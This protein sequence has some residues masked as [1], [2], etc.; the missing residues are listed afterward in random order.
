MTADAADSRSLPRETQEFGWGSGPAARLL[1]FV[2]V[3][4]SAFQ[5]W[6]A[7]Y[8]PLPS[9]V[10]RAVHVG[11]L[12]LLLFGLVANRAPE[13]RV[14]AGILWALGVMGFAVG[15]Y[16]WFFYA[17]IL[18]RAGDPNGW[19]I[20]VGTLAVVLVFIAG[21]L[22][23]GWALPIICA[24]FLAYGM[25]GQHLPSPLN[26]RG[27]DFSQIID[28]LFLGTDGIYG[29]PIYVSSTYI[30][31][32][33]L[34]GAFLERAGM[35][36]LF[37]DVALGTVGHS[38]GG[39]AKV[40]V[41]SSALMGTI[42]GSG[43]ANVVTTGQF[44][45]PLMKRFGFKPAFAGGVEATSSMGG[46]IMPPVM[47]AV[48]FIMAETL[49]IPYLDVV[50]AAI[51]P[52][53]LYF[54]TVFMMVHLEAG[55][56][57]LQGIPKAECPNAIAALRAKWHLILPLA[58]LVWLLFSGYTPLFAG[59]VGL[60]LT[61]L[62]ILGGPVSLNLGPFA[63]R[64]LFWIVL[65]V[66]AGLS[67]KTSVTLGGVRIGGITAVLI[68]LLLL[69]VAN[70]VMRGG[71]ATLSLCLD[72]LAEGAKNALPVGVACALV[73]VIIGVLSLTGAGTTF[74]RVIVSIGQSSLFLSLLLTM[75]CCLVLGMGVPTIPNYI[76]TS[77]IAGPA[78]LSLGV[79]LI[80]SHMFVFYFGIMADL[81]PPVALAAFAA[82]PIAKELGMNI[83]L[84]A[85]RIA[86]AGFVV[87]YMAVYAPALML[88]D[89]GP[90]AAEIG[91]WP[92]VAYIVFK[93]LVAIMLW[94]AAAIGFLRSR[95][96]LW[97]RLWAFVAAALLIA[98]LPLTDELGFAVVAAFLAWHVWRARALKAAPA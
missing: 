87:P 33:I 94:G 26:H 58:A 96:A 60:A 77:S 97:E 74:V 14:S 67:F 81:T 8:A 93:A 22:M 89:G 35:I 16:H 86:A 59:T 68:L 75:L 36:G 72:S 23:M 54:V 13:K 18:F 43:V 62:I 42:N 29:T 3:A 46:Q 63:V 66:L 57:G 56:L 90:L 20:A 15:L 88:Q 79:P 98:A 73:G 5:L 12:L 25:F 28:T 48:A 27:Y 38:R 2:A 51:V 45:I 34:F 92:A 82:A 69:V 78:L 49:G 47:G 41:V 85:V 39:P 80:V 55:R 31:L 76:I 44:T 70:L 53:I 17:E 9:Q 71:R 21:R 64:A 83:G 37:T 7:A 30:F 91:Y 95:L 4:F 19:D 32:F 52:A 6:T 10:I 1:F 50:K 40:A 65:G 84:N 61:A 11:F 24:L